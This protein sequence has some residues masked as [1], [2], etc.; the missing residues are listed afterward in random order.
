[1]PFSF[2]IT[3]PDGVRHDAADCEFV[4][5]PGTGGELGFLPGHSV[6]V[7]ALTP[8]RVT[9]RTAGGTEHF[10]VNGG[11]AEVHPDGVSILTPAAE[12]TGSIDV[13]RARAARDRARQRLEQRR[14]Q[15]DMA[16]AHAALD[17]ALSRLDIAGD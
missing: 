7:T 4:L 9:V 15:V 12:A 16:R 5:V 10:A 2:T 11:V 14:E 8:G 17:R 6:L 1:M 13:L 3:T